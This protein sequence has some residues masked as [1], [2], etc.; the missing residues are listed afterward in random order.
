VRTPH[1]HH[2]LE[3]LPETP[4][5][6]GD[7][8]EVPDLGILVNLFYDNRHTLTIRRSPDAP[9][10]ADMRQAIDGTAEWLRAKPSLGG[11]GS[12]RVI[13]DTA[14]VSGRLS[15]PDASHAL[16]RE[17]AAIALVHDLTLVTRNTV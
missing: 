9:R 14:Q 13:A 16:D 4:S 1:P 5:S 15:V 7:G 10:P 11:R 17:I 8:G 6:G 12:A 3:P 2:V